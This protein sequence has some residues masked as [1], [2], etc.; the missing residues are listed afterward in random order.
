MTLLDECI[1]VL[2]PFCQ[3]KEGEIKEE[4]LKKI[5]IDVNYTLLGRVNWSLY[6]NSFN[7]NSVKEL[8][9][10]T[11]DLNIYEATFFIFWDEASLPVLES[12]LNRI[13]EFIDDVTA[14]A[15]DTWIYNFEHKIIVEFHHDG[16]IVFG[17]IS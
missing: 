6:P 14:V 9:E 12:K 15:F 17:R 1:D 5:Q 10:I 13:I 11:K 16:E 8:I 2:N 3:I 4:I 7:L